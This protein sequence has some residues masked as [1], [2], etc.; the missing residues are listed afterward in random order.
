[1]LVLGLWSDWNNFDLVGGVFEN[2]T[3]S[4]DAEMGSYCIVSV[5]ARK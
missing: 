2:T 1:M 3:Q 4:K 5:R